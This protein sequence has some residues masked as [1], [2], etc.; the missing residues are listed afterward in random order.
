[1]FY[2]NILISISIYWYSEFL[3]TNCSIPV[4]S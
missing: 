3:P 2:I 4:V 1:M